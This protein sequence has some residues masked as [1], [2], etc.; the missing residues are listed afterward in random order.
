MQMLLKSVRIA[1]AVSFV[2]SGCSTKPAESKANH[3]AIVLHNSM[4]KKADLIRYRL[5]ELKADSMISRDSV[6]V[7]S[8]ALAQWQADIVEVPANEH[9]E[10]GDHDHH[11]QD[12]GH[13]PPPDVTEE[14][15]LDIQKEL[16]ERLIAIGKRV[17]N[18]KQE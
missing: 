18:L 16:D 12:H 8:H 10:H 5:D 4:M 6:A 15:M 1:V 2:L 13:N 3:E 14:Q 11:A 7:L 17:A 9:H